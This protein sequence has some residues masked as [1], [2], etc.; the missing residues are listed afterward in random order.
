MKKINT[1]LHLVTFMRSEYKMINIKKYS[2]LFVLT[3]IF[4]APYLWLLLDILFERYNRLLIEAIFVFPG[5][6]L[7]TLTWCFEL[8]C[9]KQE[10]E[11]D[12]NI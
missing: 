8:K 2:K 10:N 5:L 11:D 12:S 6:I 4:I 3:L 7:M 1:V 9:V